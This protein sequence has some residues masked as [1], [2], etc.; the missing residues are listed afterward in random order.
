MANEEEAEEVYIA[1]RSPFSAVFY[2]NHGARRMPLV[3]R[4]SDLPDAPT[5]FGARREFAEGA[6]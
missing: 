4:D 3:L 6:H 2:A 1:D 5:V